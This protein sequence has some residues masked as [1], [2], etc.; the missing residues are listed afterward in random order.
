MTLCKVISLTG[1]VQIDKVH[2]E[3]FPCKNFERL[4]I[5]ETF[6]LDTPR[7]FDSEEFPLDGNRKVRSLHSFSFWLLV[8]ASV[9]HSSVGLRAHRLSLGIVQ[10]RVSPGPFQNDVQNRFPD[11]PELAIGLLDVSF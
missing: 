3:I 11:A 10:R 8:Q 5:L 7:S 1:I 2:P 9:W 6:S 4:N